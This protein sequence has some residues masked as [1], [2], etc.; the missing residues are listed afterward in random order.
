MSEILN[1]T[2]IAETPV[3]RQILEKLRRLPA[4][5]LGHLDDFASFLV[6]RAESGFYS[7]L[8]QVAPS[9]ELSSNEGF[10]KALRLLPPS[11]AQ[12]IDQYVLFRA[13]SSLKWR[14]DDPQSLSTAMDLMARDPFLRKEM[15][16]IS[17]EF[18]CTEGD[19]LE[20][21]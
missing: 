16:A 4:E 6:T 20:P 15:D 21:Y 12:L 9:N 19:G 8:E 1:N 2:T 13:A 14:Y 5:A 3:E 11:D 10:L 7:A 18:K 17:R